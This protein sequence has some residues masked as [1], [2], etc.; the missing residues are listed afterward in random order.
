MDEAD[1]V[2]LIIDAQDGL[3]DQDKKIA[4]LSHDKGRGIIL[5]LNKWEAMPQIKNAF[6]AVRDRVHFLFWQMEYAPIIAVSARDGGGVD[7]LLN[8]AVTMYGQLNNQ[9]ETAALNQ[10]LQRWLEEYPPPSGPE[11]RF[12]V[13]YAVQVS[14][15]PVK[16]VFFVSRKQAVTGPYVAYL[17]N[18]IRRDLGFSL[19]PLDI[20]IRSSQEPSP[21]AGTRLHRRG[22]R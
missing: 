5:A 15:N 14:A 2:F 17:R 3:T 18:K 13:K 4:A 6:E 10:A 22:R 19:I 9:I 20:E 16:F 8:T 11:T 1:I 7:T 21:R 12:K